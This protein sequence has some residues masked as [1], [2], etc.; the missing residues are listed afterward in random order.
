MGVSVK[1]QFAWLWEDAVDAL[2]RR[3]RRHVADREPDFR[4]WRGE[5]GIYLRRWNL[6]PR[7]RVFN[8]YL[9]HFCQSDEDRA[10][11]DHP[12]VNASLVLSGYYFEH[13][14]RAGGVQERALRAPG[15]IILRL[16]RTAH[17][18]E[19]LG[20]PPEE[21]PSSNAGIYTCWTL[22]ITG[23]NVRE[24]GFHCPGGW[25]PWREFNSDKHQIGGGRGCE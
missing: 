23:P 4:V 8:I 22:F 16:P 1:K 2:G 5:G 9:H 10:H 20:Q 25:R 6:L 7:N 15:N 14:I 13:R 19:L 24:W 18:V 21:W 11:H 12:W 3:L 17:R